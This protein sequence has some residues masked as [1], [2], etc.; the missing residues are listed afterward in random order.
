MRTA[1][2]V[3]IGALLICF[4]TIYSVR[5]SG[6]V[7]GSKCLTSMQD[8]S[9]QGGEGV[10]SCNGIETADDCKK[11]GNCTHCRGSL[12]AAQKVCISI[13]EDPSELTQCIYVNPPPPFPCSAQASTGTCTW[14]TDIGTPVCGCVATVA[15]PPCSF[16]QCDHDD[17][18]I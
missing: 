18:V 6:P 16:K 15:A 8:C 3:G 13:W 14:I 17:P 11:G 4:G 12:S 2:N 7:L 5:G 10:N 1:A 9:S